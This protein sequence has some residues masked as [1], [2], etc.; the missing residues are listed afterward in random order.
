MGSHIAINIIIK[1]VIVKNGL[2]GLRTSIKP[3]YAGIK[4]FIAET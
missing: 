3:K 1:I 2:S 4:F